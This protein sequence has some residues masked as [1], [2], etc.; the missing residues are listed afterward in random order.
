VKIPVL[1]GV[2]GLIVC[3]EIA[4]RQTRLARLAEAEAVLEARVQE[5]A[6]AE[7]LSARMCGCFNSALR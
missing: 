7:Q 2:Q 1:P 3:D 4:I 6:A 5:R